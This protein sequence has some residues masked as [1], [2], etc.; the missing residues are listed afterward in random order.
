MYV[1][2]I[3]T[4]QE[5]AK[6]RGHAREVIT[7]TWSPDGLILASGSIDSTVRLW[8][9]TTYETL[10]EWRIATQRNDVNGLAWSP[11]GGILAAATQNGSIRL[12]D[13]ISGE[14]KPALGIYSGWSREVAWSPGGQLLASTGEDGVVRLWNPETG[15]K[16]AMLTGHHSP[17]WG[18]AWSPDG[19]RLVTGS[20]IYQALRDD[21]SVRMWGIPESEEE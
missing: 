7:T 8:D 15:E 19:T 14:E 11:D 16:L 10:A 17:V 4:G 2:D 1:F 13:S 20:G 18:V 21:T 9:A 5:S 6:L 12:W 3:E